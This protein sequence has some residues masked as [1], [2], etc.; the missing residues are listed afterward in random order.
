[1]SN[2]QVDRRPRILDFTRRIDNIRAI[3]DLAWPCDAF[4]V[5]VPVRS[6]S[7]LNIFENMFLRLLGDA[8]LDEVG[9]HQTTGLDIDLSTLI[10]CRL[11]DFGLIT[12]R[13]ELTEA[14]RSYLDENS[15]EVP[16]YEIR[17]LFRERVSGALLPIILG[18]PLSFEELLN[19]EGTRA[20][21]RIRDNRTV[22]LQMVRSQALGGLQ[23]PTPE[24]VLLAA[25][26]HAQL[27]RQYSMLCTDN[28]IVPKMLINHRLHIDPTPEQVFLRCRVVI[29]ATEDD[30]RICDP[31]GF[32]FSDT[33]FRAYETLRARPG[34]EQALINRL[35]QDSLTVRPRPVLRD[36]VEREAEEAV[37]ARLGDGVQGYS[38]LFRLLRQ[39][40]K[41][42][43]TSLTQPRNMEEEAH[44]RYYAQQAAQ[45]LAEALEA[46]LV[47]VVSSSRVAAC[48]TILVG[49]NQTYGENGK[50]LEKLAER[51]GFRPTNIGRLLDV[52]P[53]RI[54]GLR[55]GGVDL[56][57]LIAVS[58]ASAD[59]SP[60]HPFHRIAAAFPDWLNFLADLKNMRDAGAHG[61]TRKAGISRLEALRDDT[62]RSIKY[63]IPTLVRWNE[64][65]LEAAH[66]NEFSDNAHDARR[67]AISRLERKFGV[68]WYGALG[69][70]TAELFIQVELAAEAVRK[71]SDKQNVGRLVNDLASAMQA[72]VNLR[73]PVGGVD[74]PADDLP[75]VETLERAQARA[76]EAG[77]L[78]KGSAL[79]ESLRTVK[80]QRLR[81]GLSGQS[82]SLGA[83]VLAL[84]VAAPIQWLKMLAHSNPEILDLTVRLIDLRG[85]GNRPVWMSI[86]EILQLKDDVFNACD[87]LMES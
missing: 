30:Y 54:R 70:D 46:A 12:E 59:E 42:I 17:F 43:S 13:N 53:G 23:P 68:K 19:W 85:H 74:V 4:R 39:A 20:E 34:E 48:E 73:Q 52:A 26:R 8:R 65:G 58:L 28:V 38:E 15:Q 80:Q 31:F 72:M 25:R 71:G 45:S 24:E 14:G 63:L 10:C 11:R 60:E 40:E 67:Q 76:I 1:M 18:G 37:L 57:A 79:S 50:L 33:L 5:T 44:L 47:I 35:R 49:R 82:P 22:R 84:L 16:R 27:S 64:T 83:T 2:E 29:P 36:E 56:Q 9:F 69:A 7:S 6:T 51:L 81:K 86:A 55:S 61:R 66:N 78:Q 41:E 32:G 21:I 77:L 62:Y 87:A 75:M 3:R